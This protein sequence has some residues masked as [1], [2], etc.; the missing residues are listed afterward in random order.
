MRLYFEIARRSFHRAATYRGAYLA[1]LLT[2]AFFAALMTFVYRAIFGAGGTVAGFTVEEAISY[3]WIT[4]SLISI[5][6]GWVSSEIMQTI[7]SG[8]VITDL[9]RPWSFYGYWLS[10]TFGERAYNLMMRASLTYV[11]GVLLFDIRIPT[12]GETMAFAVAL[13]IAM[14]VSFALNFI[15]NLSGFWLLDATGVLMIASMALM[16][17]SGFL[18][19]IAFFPPFLAGIARLLPFQAITSLPAQVF[20]GKISGAELGPTLLLQLFWAV[21]LTVLALGLLRLAM[22]KVII[23]GG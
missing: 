7:R 12:P 19:P 1:G 4:Q 9:T 13:L 5:G 2:N 18:L 23:Q 20:L 17:F 8:E 15:V 16:F 14:F 21:A 10:R 6:G 3:T 11:L 22:R